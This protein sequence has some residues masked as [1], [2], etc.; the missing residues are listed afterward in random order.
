[1][2]KL[3]VKN[4]S[5]TIEQKF[6]SISKILTISYYVSFILSGMVAQT[7]P[8]L[9]SKWSW[10]LEWR[11]LL[12]KVI[13][14][15]LIYAFLAF[16]VSLIIP[17]VLIFVFPALGYAWLSGA[18]RGFSH[19]PWKQVTDGAAFWS[20]LVSLFY[21][22]VGVLVLHQLIINGVFGQAVASIIA[23]K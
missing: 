3:T 13:G 7:I 9:E 1:M 20:L 18:F 21:F 15:L 11:W 14:A 16:V 22:A 12:E 17:G 10:I 6:Y 19:K 5:E 2:T 4:N 8:Y 23:T